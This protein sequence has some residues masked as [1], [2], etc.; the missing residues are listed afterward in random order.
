MQ[1]ILAHAF[2]LLAALLVLAPATA[3]LRVEIT[4]VGSNQFPISVASFRRD[5]EIPQPVDEIIRA[6]LQRSG[7]FRLIEAG[8][9]P[10]PDTAATA[11]SMT[12]R[13]STPTTPR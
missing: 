1:R 9:T 2:A 12:P 10:L 3:Q 5:G 6:D 11:S 4:G 8:P 7:R 13:R